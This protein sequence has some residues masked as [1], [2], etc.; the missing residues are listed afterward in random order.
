M[1]SN[2]LTALT[3]GVVSST[4]TVNGTQFSPTS[5]FIGQP[6]LSADSTGFLLSLPN[7]TIPSNPNDTWHTVQA[8]EVRR[9]DIISYVEYGVMDYWWY[10]ALANNLYDPIADPVQAGVQLRIPPIS[11]ISS[12]YQLLVPSVIETGLNTRITT[13]DT[14]ALSVT[15]VV[16]SED[17]STFGDLVTFTATVLAV[18]SPHIPTGTV[19]FYDGDVFLGTGALD[20]TAHTSIATSSLTVGVHTI[21]AIYSGD[22][23]LNP[24]EG[25][26][27]QTVE[28]SV[29]IPQWLVMTNEGKV[30]TDNADD[31]VEFNHVAYT[32]V[33]GDT[34]VT[35][36][37][38]V[39]IDT[40]V[41][42][43]ESGLL[44]SYDHG[45]TFNQLDLGFDFHT[46]GQSNPTS[47]GR[48]SMGVNTIGIFL[49]SLSEFVSIIIG[50][51]AVNQAVAVWTADGGMT[52][53]RSD[54]P[55]MMDGYS[56]SITAVAFGGDSSVLVGTQGIIFSSADL[57]TWTAV[58][59]GPG[60]VQQINNNNEFFTSNILALST[61]GASTSP[62]GVTWT[63]TPF[64][65]SLV[66]YLGDGA[67]GNTLLHTSVGWF[68]ILVGSGIYGLYVSTD[69]GMT[70]TLVAGSTGIRSMFFDNFSNTFFA[71]GDNG[72]NR[73]LGVSTDFGASWSFSTGDT[74]NYDILDEGDSGA[75]VFSQQIVGGGA[76]NLVRAAS[77]TDVLGTLTTSRSGVW[78]TVVWSIPVGE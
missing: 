9:L 60:N 18:G 52:W 65:G 62:D 56:T 47:G 55:F 34:G 15:S 41:A 63:T 59:S 2:D 6:L 44:I 66:P 4:V 35:G 29:G 36:F 75:F 51:T 49:T 23:I 33:E 67:Y 31:G 11:N 3:V 25:D 20:S 72:T 12:V 27:I 10:I 37:I 17:P 46:Y 19:N 61:A 73:L 69:G 53:N 77:H 26:V 7:I 54:L 57:A 43:Q 14:N 13:N 42:T 8:G 71:F 5:R 70:W 32:L 22:F 74:N 21:N 45:W 39:G 58:Y 64:S 50:Y 78:G 48:V 40:I 28:E 1:A 30:R 68:T 76:G 24:S 38:K 16:S